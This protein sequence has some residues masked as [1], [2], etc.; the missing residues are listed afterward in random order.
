M[1]DIKI[2]KHPE[3]LNVFISGPLDSPKIYT[4]NSY[5]GF[6]ISDERLTTYK[7]IEYREWNPYKSKLA[8]IILGSVK[9]KL[10]D[11]N[12]KCLYLGAA[13]GTTVS[14]LSDILEK[15][16]IYSVEFAE[17]SIRQLIQ[18]TTDRTNI[19]P[20][21]ADAQHP[22]TFAKSIF[23]EIDLIYQDVAQPNQTD[24]LLRNASYYLKENGI[25]IYLVKSQSIDS[26]A[27]PEKVYAREKETLMNAGYKLL[28]S[29]D[30][31]KFADNHIAFILKKTFN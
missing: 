23:S 28:E 7:N 20:I 22:H 10:F 19:V 1:N 24:I 3:I 11:L 21:L 12:S 15:G 2:R 26:I 18:N 16:I 30:I 13:S 29:V 8:A 5:L 25:L 14:Y 6:R 4:K 27:K 31:D 17:R 9:T